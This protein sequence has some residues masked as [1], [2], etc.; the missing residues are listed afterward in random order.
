MNDNMNISELKKYVDEA[1]QNNEDT[2]EFSSH[3]GNS[4]DQLAEVP[5]WERNRINSFLFDGEMHG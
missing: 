1:K 3:V 5:F 4:M 2:T